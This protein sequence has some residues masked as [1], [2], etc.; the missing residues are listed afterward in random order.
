MSKR[1]DQKKAAR[2]Y[3]REMRAKA[4]K[5]YE[6]VTSNMKPKPKWIPWPVWLWAMGFFINIKK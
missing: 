1:Y 2:D 3:R 5:D 6:L 4:K